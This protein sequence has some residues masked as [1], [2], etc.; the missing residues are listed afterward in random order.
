MQG[1][2]TLNT[3]IASTDTSLPIAVR[4]ALITGSNSGVRFLFDLAFPW[5]YP[6]GP[7]AGRPAAG[8]PANGAAIYDMAGRANGTVSLGAAPNP[9]YAGGGFDFT[10]VGTGQVVLTPNDALASIWSA[11]NQYFMVVSYEKLPTSGDWFS[12]SGLSSH[13]CATSVS[14]GYQ[15][16]ADLVHMAQN[17]NGAGAPQFQTRRQTNG[18]STTENLQV[19]P[20]ANVYGQM[21]Q[22]AYW[23]NAAG[24]GLRI[25][26]ALGTLSG[27]SAVGSNNTGN[28]SA[29]Q[30]RWGAPI[31][32][33][34]TGN[35]TKRRLYRGWIEDLSL[36]GRDPATVLDADWAR[37]QARIAASA[38]ANGGTSLIFV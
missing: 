7:L 6:G 34:S 3:P 17:N 8:A 12:G 9:S 2:Y 24:Q 11:A 30:F 4:D 27:T 23:R 13:A 15:T 36:S 28:F 35:S 22:V 21:C 18:G 10:G 31:S 16:E 29:K 19:T 38:A 1:A 25:K 26:S 37:V 14:T 33:A 5:S 20:N 32:F